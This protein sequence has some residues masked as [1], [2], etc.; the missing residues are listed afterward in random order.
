M[1]K[2]GIEIGFCVKYKY[3]QQLIKRK[4]IIYLSKIRLIDDPINTKRNSQLSS[5]QSAVWLDTM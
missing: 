5:K 3:S 1:I 4:Y 2:S